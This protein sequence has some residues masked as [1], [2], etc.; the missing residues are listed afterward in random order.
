MLCMR[1]PVGVV[2]DEL[3]RTRGGVRHQVVLSEVGVGSVVGCA[4]IAVVDTK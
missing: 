4:R 1:E 2:V 3:S